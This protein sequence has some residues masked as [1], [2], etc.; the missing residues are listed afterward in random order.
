MSQRRKLTFT[1]RV[2][3]IL[4]RLVAVVLRDLARWA[5][6]GVPERAEEHAQSDIRVSAAIARLDEMLGA[7]GPGAGLLSLVAVLPNN[8]E[9]RRVVE[10]SLGDMRAELHHGRWRAPHASCSRMDVSSHGHA[11]MALSPSDARPD[12]LS[13]AQVAIGKLKVWSRGA[14][15]PLWPCF[16]LRRPAARTIAL[17][18]LHIDA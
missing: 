1:F 11:R 9:V 16:A 2:E 17:V 8:H 15:S 10:Q 3:L 7:T 13:P 18:T 14:N 5:N 6:N 4:W 12:A